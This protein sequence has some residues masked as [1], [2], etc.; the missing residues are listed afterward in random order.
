MEQRLALIDAAEAFVK[1]G[2]SPQEEGA[3]TGPGI[4]PRE[5]QAGVA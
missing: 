3:V 4:A 1:R 2:A 5:Q